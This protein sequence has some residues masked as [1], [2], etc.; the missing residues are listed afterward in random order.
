MLR[1]RSLVL[2][3]LVMFVL[4]L[5]ACGGGGDDTRTTEKTETAAT[6]GANPETEQSSQAKNPGAIYAVEVVKTLT[7]SVVQVA[8]ETV[9][10]GMVNQAEP[11]MG[12][13]TGVILA[14]MYYF[15][16]L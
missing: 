4:V 6:A 16:W 9:A 7:P 2:F 5:N 8:T 1:R 10:M 15:L 11:R 13:G 3:L 14:L 12:V